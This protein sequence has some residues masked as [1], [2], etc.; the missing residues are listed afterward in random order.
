MRY[1]KNPTII[2]FERIFTSLKAITS[3]LQLF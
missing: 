2:F 3:V 1:I